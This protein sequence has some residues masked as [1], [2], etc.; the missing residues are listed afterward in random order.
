MW[1]QSPPPPY[2]RTTVAL[3]Y[4]FKRENNDKSLHSKDLPKS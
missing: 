1:T 4:C 3:L 2:S